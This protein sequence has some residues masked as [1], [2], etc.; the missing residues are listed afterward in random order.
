MIVLQIVQERLA[1]LNG[2][3]FDAVAWAVSAEGYVSPTGRP[4]DCPFSL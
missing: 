3:H 2:S 1:L 4:A